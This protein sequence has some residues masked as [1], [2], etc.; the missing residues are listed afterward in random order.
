MSVAKKVCIFALIFVLL[1]AFS[2]CVLKKAKKLLSE[3]KIETGTMSYTD[4]PA[5]DDELVWDE[6]AMFGLKYPGGVIKSHSVIAGIHFYTFEELSYDQFK[7]CIQEIKDMGFTQD[8]REDEYRYQGHHEEY[9]NRYIWIDYI[10]P[11]VGVVGPDEV[12]IRAGHD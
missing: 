8:V 2:G 11:S 3:V 6:K 5:G 7:T 12:K 4:R 1:F 9:T 10:K